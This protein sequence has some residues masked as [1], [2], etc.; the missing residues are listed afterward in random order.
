MAL[1]KL[2]PA[3]FQRY[4]GRASEVEA[5]LLLLVIL[6]L[7]VSAEVAGSHAVLPA[8]VIGL[9]LASTLG[10]KRE[11]VTKLR[12]VA[13]AFITPFFFLN[14]G[15]S[16][17]LPAVYANLGLV[18]LLFAVKVGA[19]FAGVYPLGRLFAPRV[20]AYTTLLMSTGLTFGTISSVFGLQSG[21]IDRDQFSVLVVVVLLTAIV[22]TLIAQKWYD[23]RRAAPEEAAA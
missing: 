21:I 4:G 6:G 2:L 14:A 12:T 17:S 9:A 5:K 7:G 3:L 1:P 15:L 10:R 8:Y 22:P 13:F 20:A 23:P 11:V 18:A 16:V 19:K